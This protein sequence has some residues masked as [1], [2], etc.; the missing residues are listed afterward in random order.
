MATKTTGAEFKAFYN[1]PAYWPEVV[2]DGEPPYHDDTVLIVDG[3]KW[4]DDVDYSA[5]PDAASVTLTYGYVANPAQGHAETF[6]EYFTH[7]RRA[8]TITRLAVEVPKEK[9]KAVRAAVK[10]AGGTVL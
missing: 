6:E 1:D 7:W 10:A 8:Q 4:D 5:I 2:E 9:L 3:I